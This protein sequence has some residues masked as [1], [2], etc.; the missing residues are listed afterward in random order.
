M[1]S[2]QA[3]LVALLPRAP[4]ARLGRPEWRDVAL[5]TLGFVVRDL[6]LDGGYAASLDADADG[7]EGSHVTWT[8]A[9][10]ADALRAADRRVTS[11][12]SSH[13]GDWTTPVSRADRSPASAEGESFT[14]PLRLDAAYEALRDARANRVPPS[15]DEKVI[16]EWNAMLA[17]AFLRSDDAA[18]TPRGFELLEELF[19]THFAGASWWR[20]QHRRA[21]ATST[22]VAWLLEA[23]LDG[24]RAHRR[25]RV[26]RARQRARP[27]PPR[28]L[29]GRSAPER[30]RAAPGAGVFTQ[31]DQVN[32]LAMR[33]KEIF[34]G[35]TPSA[36][37]VAT[38]SLAR[39]AL[40][41]GDGRPPRG[42]PTARRARGLAAREAPECGGRPPRRRRLRPRG[43][44]GRHPRHAGPLRPPRTIEGDAANRSRH[45]P[46]LLAAARRAT[47]GFA[48]VCRGG[49]CELPS[50][51]VAQFDAQLD[52]VTASWR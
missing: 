45:R 24:Y 23:T 37:A 49:V 51:D 34:D 22:D 38:R 43:R 19:A 35:A 33:P 8:P 46:R 42:G 11:R 44:R 41:T 15:R 3:L 7:V 13:G 30:A 40:C 21:R 20:T 26:A 2:D 10:V 18:F 31:S 4:L 25:R 36:H 29:L 17:T 32:D 14:T 9:E 28:A 48:Y 52:V 5:D 12:R 1:L 47:E 6:R 16:L 27:L 50:K 39:L